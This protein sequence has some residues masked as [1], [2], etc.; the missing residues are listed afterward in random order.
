MSK[1]PLLTSL[2]FVFLCSA[3][4][5]GAPATPAPSSQIDIA[6]VKCGDLTSATPLDRAAIVMFYWGY[7]A[8]KADA[9]TFKTGILQNATRALM[10]ECSGNANEPILDA[11]RRINVKAF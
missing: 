1:Y 4:A 5:S 6:K 2:A 3:V 9:T 11:M 7:A 8:A 10:T